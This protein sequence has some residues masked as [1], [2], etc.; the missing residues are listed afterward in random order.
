MSKQ[1]SAY[2]SDNDVVEVFFTLSKLLYLCQGLCT[3]AFRGILKRAKK[4]YHKLVS[5]TLNNFHSRFGP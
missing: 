2:Y 4:F 1:L 5:E 3:D